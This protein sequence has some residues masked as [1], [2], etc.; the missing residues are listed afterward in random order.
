MDK[1]VINF[2]PYIF[3]IASVLYIYASAA[4]TIPPDQ[5]IRVVVFETLFL[6][7]LTW[8]VYWIVRDWDLTSVTLTIIVFGL[9]FPRGFFYLAGTTALL[10]VLLW[11]L[12]AWL[13]KK[14]SNIRQIVLLLNVVSV[15]LFGIFIWKL[16]IPFSQFSWYAYQKD[17]LSFSKVQAVKL[18]TFKSK[19]DIYFIVLDGYGRSDILENYYGY[20]NKSFKEYLKTRGFIL[21]EES[22][23]NYP[24]TATS[25]ASTLNMEYINTLVPGVENTY[26]WWLMKPY[27][28]HSRVRNILELEGYKSVAIA[29]DWSITDNSTVDIYYNPKP[30]RLNEFES[31]FISITPLQVF[32]PALEKFALISSFDSH[33]E[34]INYTFNVLTEL[35]ELD[36]PKFVFAHIVSPHPPFVF[37]EVGN[38]LDPDYSFSFNDANDFPGS[39]E[40]YR[41]KYVAQVKFINKQLEMTID[42]ILENSEQ[43]PII[44]LQADHGPGML[45][46]FR[47][48][49]NTCL[50]ERFGIFTA[51]FLPD[52]TP[53][54]IPSDI[55][56]VNLF[57]ILLDEY[58]GYNF[59]VL[60][61]FHYFYKDTIYIFRV[62]DISSEVNTCQ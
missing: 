59:P 8:P 38:P 26:F 52:L 2:H 10:V 48:S 62:D 47:S 33:R 22:R 7:L 20:D 41:N 15:F 30:M 53:G 5:I 16:V 49:K 21:P 23:S 19:P 18:K 58:F 3:S 51:Y 31:Y 28:N 36:G 4:I 44:L 54:T 56:P 13:R 45:T 14:K 61:Q 55:A 29:T 46:D 17:F 43:P 24:K 42:S 35:P 25:L 34:M 39:K 37:D 11:N 12:I 50:N 40:E 6:T 60:D 57:R 1:R 9:F 27:L 32:R